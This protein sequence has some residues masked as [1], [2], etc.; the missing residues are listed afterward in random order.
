MKITAIKDLIRKDVPIYYRR[1][2]SGTLVIELL[3]NTIESHIDFTVETK[4]TGVNEV[5]VTGMDAV[6]YPLLP[7]MKEIKKYIS[8]LD[9]TGG[10]PG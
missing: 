7:L 10:L 9:E 5:I 6:D 2:F 1:L 8:V 4:P 3:S